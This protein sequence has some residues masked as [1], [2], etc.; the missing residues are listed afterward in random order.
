M[1]LDI[2]FAFLSALFFRTLAPHAAIHVQP[3]QGFSVHL[4]PVFGFHRLFNYGFA[5]V[6]APFVSFS[7]QNPPTTFSRKPTPCPFHSLLFVF[8]FFFVCPFFSVFFSISAFHFVC[9]CETSAPHFFKPQR[10]YGVSRGDPMLIFFLP[11]PFYCPGLGYDRGSFMEVISH[12]LFFSL[13]LLFFFFFFF[14]Y[15]FILLFLPS[16][17]VQRGGLLKPP[18][19]FCRLM[20]FVPMYLFVYTPENFSIFLLFQLSNP[21]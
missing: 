9:R 2:V 3:L 12:L 21:S 7:F 17:G 1:S 13:F 4:F 11:P 10:M 8:A 18:V 6:V 16:L 15:C 14:F 20:V 19:F 5:L